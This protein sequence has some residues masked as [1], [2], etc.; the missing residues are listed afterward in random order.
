MSS[1]RSNVSSDSCGESLP[2]SNRDGLRAIVRAYLQ[3]CQPRLAAQLRSFAEEPTPRS[4]VSRAALAQEPDGRRYS[5]QRRIR[6]TVL[7]EARRLLLDFDLGGVS[8]FTELHSAVQRT[9]GP[10]AG[11]GELLIYDTALRIGAKLNV[12]PKAV[13][14]H[15]GTRRGARALGLEWK[16]PT[17][18][19]QDLPIVLRDLQ[20]HEVEDLLCIFKDRLR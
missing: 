13:Y 18:S 14:M 15:A 9:I 11:A 19:V 12:M 1:C 3:N 8:Q 10:I 20:P 4:A 17:I 5:H 6:R 16:Q 7:Q 2:V